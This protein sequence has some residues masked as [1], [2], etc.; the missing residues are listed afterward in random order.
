MKLQNFQL[1]NIRC[2]EDTGNVE[3]SLRINVFVGKN[4]A[5]KTTI[6]N[7]ILNL[8]QGFAMGGESMRPHKSD[9]SF[10]KFGLLWPADSISN[11]LG[12]GAG[13]Q[14]IIVT[15]VFDGGGRL[16]QSTH[17]LGTHQ[18]VFYQTRP[19]AVFEP[20]LA[21]R[22]AVAFQEV[23]NSGVSNIVT[24]NH[25]HIY[26]R[27][28]EIAVSG[29]PRHEIFRTAMRDILGFEITTRPSGGGK[30]A[31]Y[32]YDLKNFV[33]L[34]RMGDGVSE[35]VA[36]IVELCIAEDKIFVVEEP[37]TNLHPSGLKS[38]MKLFRSA[39]ERNQFI[40]TTH[41]NIVV[42]ELASQR[43]SKLFR[44]FKTAESLSSA[45]A[46]EEVGNS[47]EERQ[48]LLKEL[49]YDFADFDLFSGW[50]FLEE[51][52]S[53][54]IINK[55]LV[56][57][58]APALAGKL[59]TYSAGG[60]TKLE[61]SV[62]EFKRLMVFIHLSEAY[63]ERMFVMADGD[64][65]GK[66]VVTNLKKSFQSLDEKFIGTFSKANFEEFYPSV[67]VE[68]VNAVLQIPDKRTK[69]QAKAALLQEVTEW[70]VQNSE[71]ARAEWQKSADEP[72][73]LLN[74]IANTIL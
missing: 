31:G 54:T 28:D 56:P 62:E 1:K 51:S 34:Q 65:A 33:P 70:T 45:S 30:E 68:K 2:F 6:V 29:H 23:I 61:P 17:Q 57:N 49:G 35:I 4:N 64:D 53:E 25:Q 15:H 41:S 18:P 14:S 43:H 8:Q 66:S 48:E 13:P 52:S 60:A 12:I 10:Q 55:I 19:D 5:G 27:I 58:F 73:A 11:G 74:E 47:K 59:R 26:S 22:K 42:R 24:G 40:V 36:M 37:E 46:I 44:V 16:P 38:L 50:L 72:I 7:S 9:S 3:L 69:Q 71:L 39:S 32:Y 63:H 20:F 21:R 67:F